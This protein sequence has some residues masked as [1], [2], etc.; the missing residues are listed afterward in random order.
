[1]GL[2]LIE[3]ILVRHS[4]K[5]ALEDFVYAKVDFVFSND[6]TGPLAIKEFEKNGF[7]RV[8]SRNKIGFV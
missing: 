4:D 2:T 6:I 8:F 1:M 5:K 7:N 3:K